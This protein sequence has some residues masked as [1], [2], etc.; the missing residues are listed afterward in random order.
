MR[1][2]SLDIETTD[3]VPDVKNIL[4]IS[5]IVE[6]T[7]QPQVPVEELPHFTAF[8]KQEEPIQ[9]SLF[10]LAMNGW[11]LDIIS[12]RKKELNVNNYPILTAYKAQRE[13]HVLKDSK[14]YPGVEHSHKEMENLY[15]VERAIQFLKTHFPDNKRITVA[16]KNVAGFDI[17]F[18]PKEI[19]SLFKHKVIDPALFYVNFD[20][21]TELPSLD[22]CKKRAE[23]FTPVAHDA[24]EDA[25]DVIRLV[26]KATGPREL[27][28][29]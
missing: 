28:G 22:E 26:R 12:G 3:L 16:G 25:M 20:M 5:M 19:K 8:I 2:L 15:W 6:D 17:P 7:N 14:T 9:G 13:V 27:L 29:S 24:R 11:I 1:Y 18:L 10:A 23:I 21:D 4:Q